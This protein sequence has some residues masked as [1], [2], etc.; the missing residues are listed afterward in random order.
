MGGKTVWPR[1]E[2]RDERAE[3]L[4]RCP[5]TPALSLQERENGRPRLGESV[6]SVSPD[7]VKHLPSP[8]GRGKG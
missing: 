2:N 4:W 3:T 7:G 6:T 5:L 1:Y 8:S